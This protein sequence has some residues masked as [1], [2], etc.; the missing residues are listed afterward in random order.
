MESSGQKKLLLTNRP[1]LNLLGT[2]EP[3]IYGSMTLPQITSA[4]PNRAQ[5]DSIELKDFQSNHEGIIIERI[6]QAWEEKLSGI[7]INPAMCTQEKL[8]GTTAIYVIC[9][10]GANGYVAAL[11]GWVWKFND[12]PQTGIN[13]E[14]KK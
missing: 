11:D 10:L 1:N 8:S 14:S 12:G 9:G 7:I 3:H 13:M 4:L 5:V 6:H 2:R